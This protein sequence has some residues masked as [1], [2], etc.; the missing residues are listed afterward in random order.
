M[1]G[2]HVPRREGLSLYVPS[3]HFKHRDCSFSEQSVKDPAGHFLQDG[4]DNW[5]EIPLSDCKKTEGEQQQRNQFCRI[6][7]CFP[8]KKERNKQQKALN[9]GGRR[10][11][12]GGEGREGGG[13][14][15]GGE[16]RGGGGGVGEVEG[17]FVF[18]PFLRFYVHAC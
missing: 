7:L 10:W 9:E 4:L 11:G 12:E 5:G 2:L 17:S 1:Q 15:R 13:E 6:N 18:L 3:A 8:E 16:R 14:G